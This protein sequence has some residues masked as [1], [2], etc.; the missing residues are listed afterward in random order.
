METTILRSERDGRDDHVRDDIMR[1][2][3]RLATLLF[4]WKEKSPESRMGDP[5]LHVFTFDVREYL[6]S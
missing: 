5:C 2:R 3:R 4:Q 1:I 6:H